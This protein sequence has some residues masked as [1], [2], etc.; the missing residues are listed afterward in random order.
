MTT[1]R[2]SDKPENQQTTFT[3]QVNVLPGLLSVRFVR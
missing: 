2:R 3:K 1:G